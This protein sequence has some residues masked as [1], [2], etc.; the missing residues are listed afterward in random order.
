MHLHIHVWIRAVYHMQ[1]DVAVFCFLQRTFKRL[2]QMMRQLADKTDRIGQHDLLPAFQLQI[3][4]GWIQRCKQ[5]ILCQNACIRQPV[6]KRGFS[7]IG[8]SDDR[9]YR[10]VSLFT[11]L[12]DN[13]AVAFYFF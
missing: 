10:C 7:G 9:C 1:D 13:V 12:A 4:G 8:I 3:A 11:L 2:D 6:Q 5:L